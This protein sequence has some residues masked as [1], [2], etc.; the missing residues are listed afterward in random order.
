VVSKGAGSLRREAVGGIIS[1]RGIGGQGF[2][3]EWSS[4]AVLTACP[5]TGLPPSATLLTGSLPIWRPVS[6]NL[7]LLLAR[8]AAGVSLR[9][10]RT[11]AR[12]P[13]NLR[14]SGLIQI[15]ASTTAS[16]TPAYSLGERKR[17]PCAL[18]PGN[19]PAGLSRSWEDPLAIHC[20]D[21]TWRR[22]PCPLRL[23]PSCA[24]SIPTF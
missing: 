14:R 15:S 4:R 7:G 9:P 1:R 17:M 16:I 13:T 24:S 5:V 8:W 20:L 2:L 11:P 19:S 22:P 23:L 6:R 10:A 3:D 18:F 12:A 21:S